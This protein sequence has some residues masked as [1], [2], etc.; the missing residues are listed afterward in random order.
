VRTAFFHEDDYCQVEVLPA[1]S[2]DYCRS[3]MGRIDKFAE[4]HR[5][6]AGYTDIYVRGESPVLLPAIGI[7]LEEM[8]ASVEPLLPPFDQVFTG[9]SSHREPCRSTVA[10]GEDD[11][12]AVFARFGERGEVRAVWLSLYG[13][14][15]DRV[16]HWCR[17][18][19]ALPRAT[20]LVVANWNSSEVVSLADESALATYLVRTHG[21]IE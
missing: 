12:R 9:Y 6:G 17:V 15:P 7:A 4:A 1:A 10:W 5:D 8:R 13:V 3:E 11:F 16:G 19:R 21:R 18:L 20:E 14:E 2:A